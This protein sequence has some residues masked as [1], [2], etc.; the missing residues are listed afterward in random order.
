MIDVKFGK[1]APVEDKPKYPYFAKHNASS[2][3]VFFHEPGKG[4][5]IASSNP[6]FYAVGS[7]SDGWS[8]SSFNPFDE[9]VI[10]KN[11]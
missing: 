8:E 9:E 6:T 5:V 1:R 7:V 4:M 11:K 10:L 2:I 3:I